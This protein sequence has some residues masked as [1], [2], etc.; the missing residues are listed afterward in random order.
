MIVPSRHQP[1]LPL[2]RILL[3]TEPSAE[4]TPLDVLFVG[5]GPAG[6]AGAIELARLV[7]ADPSSGPIEIGVPRASAW[8]AQPVGAV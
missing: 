1:E 6:L 5:A 8:A 7:R 3:E 4:A 2:D